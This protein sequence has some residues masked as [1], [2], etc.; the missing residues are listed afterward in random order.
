[1][2]GVNYRRLIKNRINIIDG[3]KDIFIAMNKGIVSD[4]QICLVTNK[5][6]TLLNKM[7]EAYRCIRSL[8]VDENVEFA[9]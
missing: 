6:K 1:M 5:Y 4:E 3:I 2:N 8:I 9:F 7:D